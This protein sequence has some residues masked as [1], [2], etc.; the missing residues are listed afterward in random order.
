M[1]Y[2]I[3]GTFGN[4]GTDDATILWWLYNENNRGIYTEE[5]SYND[6]SSAVSRYF[7]LN[8][9]GYKPVKYAED[10]QYGLLIPDIRKLTMSAQS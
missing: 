9:I 7:I 2:D 8:K 4:Q 1:K 5:T 6:V 3:I 10:Y